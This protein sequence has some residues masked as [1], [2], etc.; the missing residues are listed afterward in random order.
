MKILDNLSE[1]IKEICKDNER[2][3]S[4]VAGTV[5]AVGLI[6]IAICIT[7]YNVNR[8]YYDFETRKLI[9]AVTQPVQ[10]IDTETIVIDGITY[11]K[12]K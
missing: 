2:F 12:Q 6:T 11:K 3:L 8:N 4:L 10:G 7:I 5:I 1:A 9:P